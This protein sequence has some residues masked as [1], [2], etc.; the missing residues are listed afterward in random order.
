MRD[1]HALDWLRKLFLEMD[2]IGRPI[3]G[4]KDWDDA[5]CT[6]FNGKILVSTD[7]P[8]E[9]RLVMK[10]ALIH[11]STDI[12]AKGGTP[13]F[14]L[15]NLGGNESDVAEMAHSLRRQAEFMKIPI[16]GG[17]TK[18]WDC[19][20]SAS[21]TVLGKLIL[22]EP[23][24]DSA[25]Q[26]GDVLALFGEK[27]WGEQEERL[28]AADKMFSAWYAVLDKINTTEVR[29]SACKD[30]TKGGIKATVEEIAEKSGLTYHIDCTD[31][32]LTRNLDNLLIAADE[33]SLDI[34]RKIAEKH[35]CP[36]KIIGN[37]E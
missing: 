15:D 22:K 11:A 29:I 25:A 24:R 30:V 33:N 35:K 1:I 13:I 31:E 16:L 9:K 20:P 14:A 4:I 17:N 7:G 32:H 23:L 8:Y 26:S 6:E 36:V 18:Y 2:N 3:M 10:S 27:L 5:V 34:I 19:E 28:H 21:I 12:L 37:F